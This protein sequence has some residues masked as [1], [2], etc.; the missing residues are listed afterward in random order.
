MDKLNIN[1]K[2]MIGIITILGGIMASYF[3]TKSNV[4]ENTKEII[5]H[6]AR[7]EKLEANTET[8]IRF[9]ERMKNI[10]SKTN[11]M[12]NIIVKRGT[13]STGSN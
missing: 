12:Y 10:E 9:D 1:L 2:D 11:E 7:I 4:T 6:T 13:T 8:I 5:R 3:I